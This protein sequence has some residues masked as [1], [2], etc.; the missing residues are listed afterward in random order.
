[1][2]FLNQEIF[3]IPFI[4]LKC[5]LF[6]TSKA[7]KDTAIIALIPSLRETLS[8]FMYKVQAALVVNNC[9]KGFFAGNLKNKDLNGDEILSQVF[10]PQISSKMNDIK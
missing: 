4:E 7:I 5:L 9:F 2:I 8:Q 6:S 10:Y 1:M 3:S